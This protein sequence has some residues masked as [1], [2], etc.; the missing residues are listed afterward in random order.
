MWSIVLCGISVSR[1]NKF[2]GRRAGM[3]EAAR[4]GRGA[5]CDW[6]ARLCPTVVRPRVPHPSHFLSRHKGRFKYFGMLFGDISPTSRGE[7]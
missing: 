7:R 1:V 2:G 3:R 5:P 6:R 4:R